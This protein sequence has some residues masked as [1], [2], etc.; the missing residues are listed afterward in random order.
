MGETN[1]VLLTL[2]KSRGLSQRALAQKIGLD[3]PRV[4]NI[5]NGFK[6][7]RLEEAQA[8]CGVLCRAVD[9]VFPGLQPK[10]EL[11]ALIDQRGISLSAIWIGTR[12]ESWVVR[13]IVLNG[14]RTSEH[15]AAAIAKFLGQPVDAL[16]EK[17]GDAYFPLR[18]PVASEQ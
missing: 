4:S 15:H 1:L 2:L 14:A 5:V 17:S 16:F 9:E 11:Q 8:I 13:S 3:E 12:I 6:R 10:T 7:P 18:S